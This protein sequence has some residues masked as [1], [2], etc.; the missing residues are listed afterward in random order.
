MEWFIVLSYWKTFLI[1]SCI[2][3]NTGKY[4]VVDVDVDYIMWC[5]EMDLEEQEIEKLMEE[6][7]L[8]KYDKYVAEYTRYLKAK[9]FS[10]KTIFGGK[11]S[12]T[13]KCLDRE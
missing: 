9:Y 5:R 12:C 3:T 7:E 4:G 11:H 6:Q 8:Q 1:S 13:I 10:D 2:C